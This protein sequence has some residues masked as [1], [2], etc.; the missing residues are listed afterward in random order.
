MPHV[1]QLAFRFLPEARLAVD[2]L[3]DTLA[4]WTEAPARTD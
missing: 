3:V 1:H 2:A 4:A